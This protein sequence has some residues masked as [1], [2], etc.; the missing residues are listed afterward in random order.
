LRNFISAFGI[1]AGIPVSPV[2]KA[3]K[4]YNLIEDGKSDSYFSLIT[5]K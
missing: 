1:F 2:N 4:G 3:I 5:G